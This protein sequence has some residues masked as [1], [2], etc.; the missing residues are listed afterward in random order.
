MD[1]VCVKCVFC[2]SMPSQWFSAVLSSLQ[3]AVLGGSNA[4]P[5]RSVSGGE[6]MLRVDTG[7]APLPLK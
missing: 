7:E 4:D 3:T 5:L 1:C 6:K 2:Q